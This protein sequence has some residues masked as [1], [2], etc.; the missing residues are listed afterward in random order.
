MHEY[1]HEAPSRPISV[2][3]RERRFLAGDKVTGKIRINASAPLDAYSIFIL[4]RGEE[5]ASEGF[6]GVG[7]GS[8]ELNVSP[9]LYLRQ[10]V[11]PAQAPPADTQLYA[12]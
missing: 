4:L 12:L 5:Q 9:F 1:L 2:L 3:L 7:G 10:Y 11:V 6:H 8:H